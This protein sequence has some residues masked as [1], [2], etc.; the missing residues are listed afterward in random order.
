MKSVLKFGLIVAKSGG[1][2]GFSQLFLTNLNSMLVSNN[3][4]D[5]LH[6]DLSKVSKVCGPRR[7]LLFDVWFSMFCFSFAYFQL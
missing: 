3:E 1:Q 6:L 5:I 2:F 4:V 7:V